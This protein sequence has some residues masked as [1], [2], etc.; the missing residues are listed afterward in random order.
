M[1]EEPPPA[2]E[3]RWPALWSCCR[4]RILFQAPRSQSIFSVHETWRLWS[5]NFQKYSYNKSLLLK[6]TQDG[7]WALK[8]SRSLQVEDRRGQGAWA[9]HHSQTPF[10]K[11]FTPLCP[12]SFQKHSRKWEPKWS[13][14]LR[15]WLCIQ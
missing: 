8:T 1:T 3:Q 14:E 4:S 5:P 7:L 2:A 10:D 11:F 15:I 9:S 13:P 12:H 6:A